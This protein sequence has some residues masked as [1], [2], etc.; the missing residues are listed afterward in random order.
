MLKG[1]KEFISRGNVIDLAVAVVI[2]AAFTGLVTAFT[3]SVVQPL[4]DRIGAGPDQ[5]YGILRIPLG[6]E[7]FVDLNAVLSATIN[8]LLVALVLYFVIVVPYKKLKER[9]TKVEDEATELTL[10]TEIRDLLQQNANGSASGRHGVP[11]RPG[12]PQ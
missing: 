4:I 3:D 9:D 5:E 8:F 2:G 12:A 10:L 1:F 7:Q 11:P 6:G